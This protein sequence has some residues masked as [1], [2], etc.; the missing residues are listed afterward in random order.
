MML[1]GKRIANPSLKRERMNGPYGI[2]I[3]DMSLEDA[4]SIFAKIQTD[5]YE[6]TS[7]RQRVR[8]TFAAMAK[9]IQGYLSGHKRVGT[10]VTEISSDRMNDWFMQSNRN[11]YSSWQTHIND[12]GTLLIRPK[13]ADEQEEVTQFTARFGA[14]LIVK[15]RNNPED[16]SDA[17]MY[18]GK[19]LDQTLTQD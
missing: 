1:D 7:P 12:Q 17:Y 13:H 18:I 5:R 19:W 4:E 15:A 2:N 11:C 10:T 3:D 8:A 6:A 16:Y 14:S 9:R